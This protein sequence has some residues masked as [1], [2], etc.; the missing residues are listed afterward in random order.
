[1]QTQSAITRLAS[2]VG[3]LKD[4]PWLPIALWLGVVPALQELGFLNAAGGVA[5]FV[6][7]CVAAL[8]LARL[9]RRRYGTVTPLGPRPWFT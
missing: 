9:Y 1:M 8:V 3:T 6:L 7:A 2:D 4:P 5:G